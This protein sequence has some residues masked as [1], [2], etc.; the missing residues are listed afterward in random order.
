MFLF[1]QIGIDP[2]TGNITGTAEEQTTRAMENP[3]AVL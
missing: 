3:P 2:A 1:G